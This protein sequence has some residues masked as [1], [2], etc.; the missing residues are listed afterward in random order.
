[1]NQIICVK[2]GDK[3][4]SS[5]VNRL[6]DMIEKN[7]T[8][9]FVLYCLTDDARDIYP[10]VKPLPLVNTE[11]SGWWHKL[12]LF[13]K[14][15]HQLEGELLYMDLDVVIVGGLDDFFSYK[16][17]S[18]LIAEDLQTRGYNSSVFRFNIG[19]QPQVWDEFLENSAQVMNDYYGDQNWITEK[20]GDAGLW[21]EQWVVSFKKQCRARIKNSYGII[22]KWLR[23]IGVMTVTG[24]AII[25]EGARVIQFHGKPDPDDVMDGPYDI[26]RKAPWIKEYRG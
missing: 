15:F 23:K 18:F 7:M 25:P 21:P 9:D 1:M 20:V 16:P 5:Y 19:S 8:A 22:G 10:K 12:S 6:Y 17:G 2:W 3:Y 4:P 14:D 26:Y 11:I 24:E 13:Q